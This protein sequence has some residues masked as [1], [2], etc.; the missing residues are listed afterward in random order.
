MIRPS[1]RLLTIKYFEAPSLTTANH[2]GKNK[3]PNSQHQHAG[4]DAQGLIREARKGVVREIQRH[5]CGAPGEYISLE[6]G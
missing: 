2:T 5:Q 3:I 1:N 6:T 4:G